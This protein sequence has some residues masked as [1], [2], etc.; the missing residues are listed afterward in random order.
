MTRG[1]RIRADITKKVRVSEPRK[2][3]NGHWQLIDRPPFDQ[4]RGRAVCPLFTAIDHMQ[5]PVSAIG[6]SR[7]FADEEPLEMTE[8]IRTQLVASFM[9]ELSEAIV[10]LAISFGHP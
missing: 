2:P 5:A 1:W 10:S 9:E 6:S 4:F 3:S 7:S 8:R